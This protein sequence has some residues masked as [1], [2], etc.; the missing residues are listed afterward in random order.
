LSDLVSFISSIP[1]AIWGAVIASLLTL[2]GVFFTNRE[3]RKSLERQLSHDVEKLRIDRD[4][5]LKKDVFLEAA[6]S[7]SKAL[8]VIGKMG[9]VDIPSND[10]AKIFD[11]HGPIASKMY[12][13]AKEETVEHALD[14]SNEISRIYLE[15][16]RIRN[17]FQDVKKA[18]DIYRDMV[19]KA[20]ADKGRVL[21]TMKEMNL[22]G[23]KDRSKFDYLNGLFEMAEK[24]RSNA[25]KE[26][27]ELQS[28][29]NASYFDFMKRCM[30]E[31]S[32]LSIEIS[33]L[34]VA[35]RSELNTA[36]DNERFS[37]IMKHAMDEMKGNFEEFMSVTREA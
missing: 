35:V 1:D 8:S 34:I 26:I 20:D 27:L 17:F 11:E 15:L 4:Y 29:H 3:N 5:D 2:S 13:I 32:R 30:Q 21:E 16:L 22:S 25:E 10:L 23:V 19:S 12:L 37:K 28:K 33:G 24:N 14:I 6:S 31:Y 18:I 7:Y 36:N 9:N